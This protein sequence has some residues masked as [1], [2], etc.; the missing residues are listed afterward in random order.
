MD[1]D[2]QMDKQFPFFCGKCWTPCGKYGGR[3]QRW[4]QRYGPG[5]SGRI[6]LCNLCILELWRDYT[7]TEPGT[8]TQAHDLE[9]NIKYCV[10]LQV[11]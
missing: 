1:M 9:L 10:W 2:L 3:W 11:S 4:G 7:K 5:A 6:F 8:S